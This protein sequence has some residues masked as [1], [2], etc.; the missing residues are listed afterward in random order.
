MLSVPQV[1][2]QSMFLFLKNQ[3]EKC[4]FTSANIAR[5]L[6][7]NLYPT[8]ACAMTVTALGKAEAMLK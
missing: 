6:T 7:V 5:P 1:F 8:N 2:E 3:C 4:F